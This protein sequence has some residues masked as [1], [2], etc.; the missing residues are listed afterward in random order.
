MGATEDVEAGNGNRAS[1]APEDTVPPKV[2]FEN[3]TATDKWWAV[4]YV[5]S[6]I[7]FLSTGSFIASQ[8]HD[9][10]LYTFNEDG[11]RS[12]IGEH[13]LEDVQTCCGDQTSGGLCS[14]LNADSENRRLQERNSKF[15]GDEGIFD[16]F[17]E[18]PE[19]IIG[20]TALAFG[21][22]FDAYFLPRHVGYDRC[23]QKY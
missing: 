13:F 21:K 7:A 5:L 2:E 1:V 23:C 3:R 20:L 15:D 22:D 11:Y 18:A 19:I 17:I 6:Y 10:D 12:G 16:A 8:A 9:H 4:A 14:Y